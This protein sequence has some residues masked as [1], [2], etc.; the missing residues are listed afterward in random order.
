MTREDSIRT[1]TWVT[2]DGRYLTVDEITDDH[3]GNIRKMLLVDLT[4]GYDQTR[5]REIAR[6][7]VE[8]HKNILD[9]IDG[10]LDELD[11]DAYIAAWL[12]IL[13]NEVARRQSCRA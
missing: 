1:K 10:T 7:F 11:R 2:D 6:D 12:Q 4:P 3:L 9:Y 8:A 13:D 5:G